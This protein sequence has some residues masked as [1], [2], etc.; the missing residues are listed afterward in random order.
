MA[1]L[2]APL[3]PVLG[4]PRVLGGA[5]ADGEASASVPRLVRQDAQHGLAAWE[6]R[7]AGSAEGV[8]ALQEGRWT[9]AAARLLGTMLDRA[10]AD[11]VVLMQF[12]LL[13]GQA[14][15]ASALADELAGASLGEALQVRLVG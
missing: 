9:Q 3:I 5:R 8:V 10:A 6:P 14:A 7:Y 15:L 11:G 13:P 1:H 12:V 2:P 4:H